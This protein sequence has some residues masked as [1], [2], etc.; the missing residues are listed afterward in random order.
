MAPRGALRGHYTC[1]DRAAI[2][3][4][5]DGVVRY[6]HEKSDRRSVTGVC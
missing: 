6:A 4:R 1:T 2:E 5:D 3:A